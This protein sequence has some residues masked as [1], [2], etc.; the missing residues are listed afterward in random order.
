MLCARETRQTDGRTDLLPEFFDGSLV[1]VRPE[2]E[3]GGRFLGE[4][5][6]AEQG[7]DVIAVYRDVSSTERHRIVGR[8]RARCVAGV[9][10]Q[11]ERVFARHVRTVSDCT[12]AV[13][14][15]RVL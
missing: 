12:G 3:A 2:T 14:V 5:T 11:G 15:H 9:E 1:V 8:D 4:L 13:S 10:R 6:P 7:F